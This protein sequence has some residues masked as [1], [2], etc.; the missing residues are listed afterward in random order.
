MI[1]AASFIPVVRTALVWVPAAGYLFL[2]GD[3]TWALFIVVWG[4]AV[5]GSIDN[6]LRPILM[7]GSAGMDTLMIFLPY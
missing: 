3:I 4:I 2:T 7:Q 5:I 6:L 1:G